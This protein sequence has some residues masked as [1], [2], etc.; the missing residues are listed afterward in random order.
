MLPVLPASSWQ[1]RPITP[2]RTPGVLPK[3]TICPARAPAVKRQVAL[4]PVSGKA[5]A[6]VESGWGVTRTPL[7]PCPSRQGV[8][9]GPGSAPGTPSKLKVLPARAPLLN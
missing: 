9:T 1:A 6:W 2:Q 5:E 8:P 7:L 4:Q 3:F